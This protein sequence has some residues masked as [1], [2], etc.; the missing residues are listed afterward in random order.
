MEIMQLSHRHLSKMYVKYLIRVLVWH[1]FSY[2]LVLDLP[3]A[4]MIWA[5]GLQIVSYFLFPYSYSILLWWWLWWVAG[6][7]TQQPWTVIQNA[8]SSTVLHP[9]P[10][11]GDQQQN[12]VRSTKQK[13]RHKN[14]L[15]YQRT[16]RQSALGPSSA[17]LKQGGKMAVPSFE[18]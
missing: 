13:T 10:K 8:L 9:G 11:L 3:F 16:A 5:W 18:W 1:Y 12:H 14:Q 2:T 7:T 17:C 15:Q 4:L 6:E